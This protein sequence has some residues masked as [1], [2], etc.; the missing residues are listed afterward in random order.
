MR[1]RGRK[2]S[3]TRQKAYEKSSIK[4]GIDFIYWQIEKVNLDTMWAHLLCRCTIIKGVFAN[5]SHRN[6]TKGVKFFKTDMSSCIDFRK[7]SQVSIFFL[8]S[9]AVVIRL[10]HE[11]GS[12][13]RNN[14]EIFMHYLRQWK[15]GEV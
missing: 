15:S 14:N 4:D 6:F 12:W 11:L 2:D 13:V 8:Q 1:E 5:R 9:N 3:A 7:I 10:K